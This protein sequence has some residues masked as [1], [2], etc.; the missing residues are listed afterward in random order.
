M[1]LEFL[2]FVPLESLGGFKFPRSIMDDPIKLY[3]GI[4]GGSK[5]L[6]G[7]TNFS[8][9]LQCEPRRDKHAKENDS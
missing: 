6:S 7:Y 3:G 8:Q 1:R 4:P 9:Q 5:E 2:N